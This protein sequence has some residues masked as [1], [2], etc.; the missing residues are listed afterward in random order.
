MAASWSRPS[1]ANRIQGCGAILAPDSEL[2]SDQ[3]FELHPALGLGRELH[4]KFV[5][6]AQ[7][8]APTLEES[9]FF[10]F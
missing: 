10:V 4:G 5:Q 9:H 3:D 1:R 7:T 8:S 2:P 6:L